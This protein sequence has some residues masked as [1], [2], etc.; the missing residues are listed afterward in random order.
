[1]GRGPGSLAPC[2][3]LAALFS[4]FAAQFPDDA[5]GS[6]LAVVAGVGASQALL[7]AFPAVAIVHFIAADV[8][9]PSGMKAAFHLN[10]PLYIIAKIR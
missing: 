6:R 5:L 1:L 2:P 7:Q 4:L 3:I 8:G 10:S 9:F